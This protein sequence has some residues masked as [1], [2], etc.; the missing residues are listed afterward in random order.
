MPFSFFLNLTHYEKTLF[1]SRTFKFFFGSF[2]CY[3]FFFYWDCSSKILIKC[4]NARLKTIKVNKII[5]RVRRIFDDDYKS[6]WHEWLKLQWNKTAFEKFFLSMY[7]TV[8]EK[9]KTIP[10]WNH[11]FSIFAAIYSAKCSKV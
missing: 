4:I 2:A 11:F 7:I 1:F 9:S 8:R 6:Y 5:I 10:K 3:K